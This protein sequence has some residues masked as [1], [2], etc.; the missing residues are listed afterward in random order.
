MFC[1][2]PRRLLAA[3]VLCLSACAAHALELKPDGQSYEQRVWS[4]VDGAPQ[5]AYSLAQDDDGMLFFATPT[6]LYSFDGVRFRQLSK[7]YG[8]ALPSSSISYVKYIPGGLALGYHFGGLSIFTRKEVTH[9][10]AGKDFPR[11]TIMAIAVDPHG[12]LHATTSEGLVRLEHGKWQRVGQD[13][14]PPGRIFMIG[15][16]GDGALWAAMN[17][18]YYVRAAGDTAFARSSIGD[19]RVAQSG[20]GAV[21]AAAPAIEVLDAAAASATPAQLQGTMYAG[22][23]GSYWGSGPEGFVRMVK[24]PDGA[25]SGAELFPYRAGD[26][27]GMLRAMVDREGNLWMTTMD[28]VM[29]FRKHR[30]QRIDIDGTAYWF[31]QRGLGDEM[32]TGSASRPMSRIRADGSVVTETIKGPT[33][34]LRANAQHAWVAG[35][36]GMAEYQG[37]AVQQWD[38]PAQLGK[39]YEVQALALE[40]GGR[41]LAS[42]VRNGLWTFAQGVWN[43]DQRLASLADANPISMLTD[44]AGA[45]WVGLTNSR[46]VKLTQTAAEVLPPSANLQVGNVLSMVDLGGRL[47]VGGDDGLAWIQGG[48]A[49]PL[50]LA[51]APD[52]RRVTGMVQD[53]QGSLW[54][55]SSDGLYRVSAQELQRFWSAPQQACAGELFNFEDGIRGL[56]AQVRPLP[57]LALGADGR[58]YYATTSQTGWI[59]PRTLRRNPLPP[60]VLIESL[61]VGEQSYAATNGLLLPERTTAIDLAFT[62]TALSIPGRVRLKYRLDGVDSDWREASRDRHVQYTNLAPGP[63]RFRVIAANEDGVWNM[64]GAQFEFRIKAAFWQTMWFRVLCVLAVF[65]IAVLCYRW[66]IA[67]VRRRAEAHAATRHEATLQERTRIARTLHDNLLQAA[68]ALLLRFQTVQTRLAPQPEMQAMLDKVIDYAEKLVESTRDEVM[69]LRSEPPCE[70]IIAAL[71]SAVASAAPGREGLLHHETAGEPRPL[72]SDAAVEI[73]YVLREAVLN[74]VLHAD[75]TR[76]DVLLRFNPDGFEGQVQDDGIGIS[77]DMARDGRAGH[78]GLAGMRE[79]VARLGGQIDIVTGASGGCTVRFTLPAHAAYQA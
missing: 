32:W 41:L 59:D 76:I 63:Y 39:R 21:A 2:T 38:F 57:S 9:Y 74:S 47:L 19:T 77:A 44:A 40:P 68:Q 7:L 3:L 42:F 4:R 51:Q 17:D 62:A 35:E 18:G 22:P 33:A 25:L 66:R 46:V 45:T 79:R 60:T 65:L 15:F 78:W 11:G 64:Q 61:G 23:D 73:L 24:T 48:K 37:A 31:T 20:F 52:I 54:I 1:I 36:G 53:Q 26:G 10:V 28:N 30:L 71:H 14:L 50:R 56:G 67:V 12:V 8:H 75:A 58:V 5:Q 55:H 34:I 27:L 43:K 69:G 49:W 16:A 29:R 70:E 13:S 72:R 6:G